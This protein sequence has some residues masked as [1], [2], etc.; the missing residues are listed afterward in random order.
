MELDAM[1][2]LAEP[3]LAVLRLGHPRTAAQ[4]RTFVRLGQRLGSSYR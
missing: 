1:A 3:A 2:I 4:E